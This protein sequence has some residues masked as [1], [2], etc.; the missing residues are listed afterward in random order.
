MFVVKS[1]GFCM[2]DLTLFRAFFIIWFNLMTSV[3]VH[4]ILFLIVLMAWRDIRFFIFLFYYFSCE[5]CALLQV[6]F[7]LFDSI[8]NLVECCRIDQTKIHWADLCTGPNWVR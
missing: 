6:K 2:S 7:D 4:L 8:D 3:S 1:R 5:K